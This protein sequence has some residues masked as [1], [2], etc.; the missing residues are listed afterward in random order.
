MSARGVAQLLS[1]EMI[2]PLKKSEDHHVS[3]TLDEL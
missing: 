1:E 3:M 2:S